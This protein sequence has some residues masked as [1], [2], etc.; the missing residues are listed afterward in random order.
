MDITKLGIRLIYHR[1]IVAAITKVGKKIISQNPTE[2]DNN[3]NVG[4]ISKPFLNV[5]NLAV[6][7]TLLVLEVQVV[8]IV[9]LTFGRTCLAHAIL[10]ARP[11]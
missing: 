6:T 2:I 4:T 5:V 7:G 9:S 3:I 1:G 11:T 8:I 10:S